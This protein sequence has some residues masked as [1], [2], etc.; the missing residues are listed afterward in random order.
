MNFVFQI[1]QCV[2]SVCLPVS[3]QTNSRLSSWVSHLILV[4]AFTFLI[5]SN[6]L[7]I[8]GNKSAA[9]QGQRD[10]GYSLCHTISS[11]INMFGSS[12]LLISSHF[13][14]LQIG[15][16]DFQL[17]YTLQKMHVVLQS[18]VSPRKQQKQ[19]KRIRILYFQSHLPV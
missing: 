2:C 10:W 14:I 1:I 15:L 18:P 8:S 11:H 16:E 6:E 3:P 19:G 13:Q 9:E 12:F 4:T 5:Q 17:I 7:R